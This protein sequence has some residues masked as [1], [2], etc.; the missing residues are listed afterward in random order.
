M[1][2]GQ[3][4]GLKLSEGGAMRRS[5]AGRSDGRSWRVGGGA[6]GGRPEAG[7]RVK[8][9]RTNTDQTIARDRHR[10]EL[11]GTELARI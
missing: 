2:A 10:K 4:E 1:G 5:V 3:W 6:T 11:A 7:G 8:R 9:Q